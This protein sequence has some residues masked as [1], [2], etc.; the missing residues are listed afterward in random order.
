MERRSNGYLYNLKSRDLATRDDQGSLQFL[1]KVGFSDLT[2]GVRYA[3]E[4]VEEMRA[5][6]GPATATT[7][8]WATLESELTGLQEQ[9]L[10]AE[11]MLNQQYSGH[12]DLGNAIVDL[13]TQYNTK[14]AAILAKQR[15]L[16]QVDDLIKQ[17]AITP[18][19][20]EEAKWRTI[21]PEEAY[22]AMFPTLKAP[23]TV[24]PGE[25]V[26][27][28]KRAQEFIA[29]VG[30]W[31]K[32][33]HEDLV[34]PYL[35]FLQNEAIIQGAA[36]YEEL[37]TIQ[38]RQI[39]QAWDNMNRSQRTKWNPEDPQLR[40]YRATGKLASAV[41]GTSPMS[42][43]IKKEKPSGSSLKKIWTKLTEPGGVP[44]YAKQTRP[45]DRETAANL[46]K[47][48]GGDKTKARQLAKQRGYS[49]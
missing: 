12:P 17:G 1:P 35:R 16:Q 4:T 18:E 46:L 5:R 39:N 40:P 2:P 7:T 13:Q 15:N 47:E 20:G 36:N 49:I 48:V 42:E 11:R 43:A 37:N 45:L 27:S 32:K 31:G 44:P 22:R 26:S 30:G 24:T 8:P 9:T 14:K 10:A 25:F 41:T 29:G 34:E 28:E 3:G 21:L 33:E 23:A 19:L 6:S 38:K